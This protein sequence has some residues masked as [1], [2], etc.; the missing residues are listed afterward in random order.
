[1]GRPE[2]EPAPPASHW[3]R[4]SAEHV[5][6]G[7]RDRLLARSRQFV[8]KATEVVARDGVDGLTLRTILHETG[9]SRRAFYERFASKDDLLVA[10]FEETMQSAAARFR[11]EF[12]EHGLDDPFDR[13]RFI[14]RGMIEGA[15]RQRTESGGGLSPAM[16]REHLRLA[17]SRPDELRQAV[18]PT[19]NLM[20]DQIAAAMESGQARRADPQELAVLVHSLVSS[21]IHSALFGEAEE[22]ET[23]RTVRVVWE[24]CR[25]AL[26]A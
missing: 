10:V 17:E 7:A 20:A 3:E 18:A 23:E 16:S 1:M 6:G 9:L 26:T 25:R 13:L 22:Y 5:V 2:S 14:V 8:E 21:T 4:R 11:A 12:E 19:T 24:F 15:E